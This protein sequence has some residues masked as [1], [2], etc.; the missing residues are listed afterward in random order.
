MELAEPCLAG[1]AHLV[2]LAV[3]EAL[4]N[5]I[6]HGGKS[7]PK[8]AP[9]RSSLIDVDIDTDDRRLEVL[10]TDSFGAFDPSQS[11]QHDPK[12]RVRS[13]QR[14][15]LGLSIIRRVMDEVHYARVANARNE[16]RLVKYIKAGA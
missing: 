15:G 5:V 11:V 3:D 6:L 12:E 10:I 4:A 16:L 1:K 2:A 8:S 13:R 9:V 14:G 7:A